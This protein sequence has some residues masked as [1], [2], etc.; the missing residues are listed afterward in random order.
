MTRRASK[1]D[2]GLRRRIGRW[3]P[4]L[5]QLKRALFGHTTHYMLFRYAVTDADKDAPS[6]EPIHGISCRVADESDIP[7]IV[8]TWPRE[9]DLPTTERLEDI[10]RRRFAAGTLCIVSCRDDKIVG[11]IW[12]VP[13]EGL[14][15][16]VDLPDGDRM[17]EMRNAY[18]VPE[19]RG[20][21]AYLGR[22][23]EVRRRAAAKGIRGI[24]AVIEVRPDRA[25]AVGAVR[26]EG[27]E[28]FG[29]L[30]VRFRFGTETITW[31]RAGMNG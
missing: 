17:W 4:R 30:R 9:F 10:L 25:A 7:Q 14:L 26:K 11:A 3:F 23:Q 28:P 31:H 29:M 27:F 21:G 18:L 22:W 8:S 16:H 12:A 15:K 1:L 6:L 20:V 2:G 13:R 19:A 5:R 24:Y